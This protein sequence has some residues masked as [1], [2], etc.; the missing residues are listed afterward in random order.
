MI[1][2]DSKISMEPRIAVYLRVSTD[3]NGAEVD[4]RDNARPPSTCEPS[5]GD[6][7]CGNAGFNDGIGCCPCD[8]GSRRTGCIGMPRGSV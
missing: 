1:F 8:A 4:P 3:H 2:S 6:R 7:N 5:Y